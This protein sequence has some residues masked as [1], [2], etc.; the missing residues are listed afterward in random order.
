MSNHQNRN[1]RVPVNAPEEFKGDKTKFAMFMRQVKINFAAD[2][3]P[4]ILDQNK[5]LYTLSYMRD[6]VAG[7]WSE[8]YIDAALATNDW[9]T[10]NEFETKLAQSFGDPNEKRNAQNALEALGQDKKTA[11]EF[12]LEFDQLARRADYATGHDD[13]LICLLEKNAN[14]SL[15]DRVY[16]AESL[17][18]TYQGWRTKI[19][20]LDQLTRRRELQRQS[21]RPIW[22]NRKELTSVNKQPGKAE[23]GDKPIGDGGKVFGGMGQPMDLDQSK[24]RSGIKCY[25]CGRTGHLARQCMTPTV[26]PSTSTV[27]AVDVAEAD[28]D[29]QKAIWEELNKKFAEKDFVQ[30]QE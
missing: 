23:K 4:F 25:K 26:Q 24:S 2:P 8:A 6:S 30:D 7:T 29:H 17:P 16:D 13:E 15:I 3:I 28:D 10:W 9:G 5:I 11:E 18:T 21:R 19:I 22:L 12:F 27:R 14:Q 20:N 1:D